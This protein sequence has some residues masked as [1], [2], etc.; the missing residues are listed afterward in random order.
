MGFWYAGRAASAGGAGCGRVLCRTI[1][2]RGLCMKTLGKMVLMLG[3][4]AR[5][6]T[7]ACN[8]EPDL[9]TVHR[10]AGNKHLKNSE[11]KQAA[12]EYGQSLQADPKQEKVWEKKAYAHVQAGDIE[13]ADATLL[14][15]MEFMSDVAKKAEMYRNL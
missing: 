13:Q 9:A 10:D 2:E 14:K 12:D 7:T 3:A 5:S 6:G 11:W 4:L 1:D 8:K 15:S